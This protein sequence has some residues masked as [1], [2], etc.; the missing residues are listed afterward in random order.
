MS[1]NYGYHYQ[2]QPQVFF[3][4]A[5]TLGYTQYDA[6]RS[7]TPTSLITHPGH[8]PGPLSTPPQSRNPSQPPEQA[9]D[10]MIWDDAVGSQSNSPTSVRTPED[11]SFDMEMLDAD[12]N[13][14]YQNPTGEVMTTQV[15]QDALN[16]MDLSI[17][18]NLSE[19]GLSSVFTASTLR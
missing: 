17:L 12:R 15:S 19:Q 16:A 14:Y 4:S 6:Q 9:P 18:S 8:S 5:N 13:G 10:Q 1:Y 3:T 2:E 11:D 7:K